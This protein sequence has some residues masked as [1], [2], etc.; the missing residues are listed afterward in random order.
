VLGCCQPQS[1]RQSNRPRPPS[2]RA[3]N[4]SWLALIAW[5]RTA[6]SGGSTGYGP[7]QVIG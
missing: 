2:N 4:M 3:R 1:P 6:P 5:P 7:W